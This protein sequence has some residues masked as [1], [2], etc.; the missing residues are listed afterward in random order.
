[1]TNLTYTQATSFA[2]MSKLYRENK[3]LDQA[4]LS[5]QANP[6]LRQMPDGLI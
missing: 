6:G 5:I 3:D 2:N 4:Y 1:M